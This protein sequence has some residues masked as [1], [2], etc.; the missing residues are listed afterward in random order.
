MAVSSYHRV[1][2]HGVNSDQRGGTSLYHSTGFTHRAMS[3]PAT[4]LSPLLSIP[5][6]AGQSEN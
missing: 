6:F 3:I 5:K 2:W 1:S 4:F